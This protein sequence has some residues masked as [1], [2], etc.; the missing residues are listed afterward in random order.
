MALVSIITVNYNSAPI[1][2]QLLNSIQQLNCHQDTEVIVVD[3][4]SRLNPVP[5]W[6]L[7]FPEYK[8]FRSEKN[9]GFAGGNNLGIEHAKGDFLFLINN[10]TEITS[11]LVPRLL[12]IMI[13]RP[14]I[15]IASPKILYYEKK[16]IIQYA[17][18]TPMN[19]LTARNHCIGQ[20]E[21][22]LGQYDNSSGITAYAHGAAMMVR[23]EALE[24]AGKMAENFFL[25]YEEI[26]WCEQMKKAGYDIWVDTKATIYHKESMS[27]GKAS[28]IKEYFMHRNRILFI[29]K[30]ATNTQCRLFLL[31]YILV[32]LPK[33]M[34]KYTMNGQIKYAPLL[35]RS[36]WWNF[37]NKTD[38]NNLYIPSA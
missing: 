33:S 6:Q 5:Q 28:S 27:V 17:G 11:D 36:I 4:A 35:I 14:S 15:G 29:R 37:T 24:K 25:Y 20:F 19:F 30:N 3:N 38:S 18:Y 31:Y 26:D 21:V 1:T 2:E 22:D 34:Y 32:V 12:T 7:R 8:F 16:E 23:R 10:D 9:L 13:Q